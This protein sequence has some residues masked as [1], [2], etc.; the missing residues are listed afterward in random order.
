M[1]YISHDVITL[2]KRTAIT[3]PIAN[4]TGYLTETID[5]LS[6]NSGHKRGRCSIQSILTP[7]Q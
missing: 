7:Q 5:T 1:K 6:G 3:E 2:G 4:I